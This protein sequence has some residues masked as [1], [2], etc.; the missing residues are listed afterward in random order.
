[1]NEKMN[2]RKNAELDRAIEIAVSAHKGKVDKAYA[3]YIM[4]PPGVMMSLSTEAERIVGTVAYAD[5]VRHFA[6]ATF[7]MTD[8]KLL[9]FSFPAVA[10][11]KVAIAPIETDKKLFHI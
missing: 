4:H 3:P 6:P 9:P 7:A 8:G 10:R 2:L 5:I 11:K 1:M